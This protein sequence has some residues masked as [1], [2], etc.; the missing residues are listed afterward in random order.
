VTSPQYPALPIHAISAQIVSELSSIGALVLCAPTGSGKT[1][2]VPQI[3]LRSGLDHGGNIL[4]LQP[5]RLATRLVATRVADEM[6]TSLGDVVGFQTRLESRHSA[7]TRILF[8]TEGLFLRRLL[9]DPQLTGIGAVIIDEFHERSLA[10]DMALGLC[11]QLRAAGRKDLQLVVMSATLDANQVAQWLG[12]NALEAQGR[13]YPVHIDYVADSVEVPLWERA[14]RALQQWLASGQDG[15][16][17]VFMPGAYEIRRCVELFSA[18]WRADRQD[19]EVVPLHGSLTPKEQ[20]RAVASSARR[21]IIV[22]TNVAET[23]I[24]ID[25]I[26]CVIDAGLARVARFDPAR[27]VNSLL[28]ERISMASAQQ[29]AGRAGRTAPGTCLRL[30]PRSESHARVQQDTPEVERVDLSQAVLQLAAM[31]CAAV[32]FA[33]LDLPPTQR[34]TDAADQL[35]RLGALDELGTLTAAGRAMANIPAHPRL[36]RLLSLATDRGVGDRAA[37]W[38]ALI[39]ERDICLRPIA[40]RYRTMADDGWPSDL[41]VRETGL[42]EAARHRFDPQRCATLGLNAA[43]CREVHRVAGQFLRLANNLPG[44]SKDESQTESEPTS[45]DH[46]ADEMLARCL[47]VAYAD[48]VGLRRNTSS[49]ACEMEGRRRVRLDRD[50]SIGDCP[51]FVAVELREV[52]ASRADGGGVQ[53]IASLATAIEW[54]WLEEELPEQVSPLLE[55]EWDDNEKAVYQIDG[56]RFGALRLEPRRQ[57]ARNSEAAAQ[58]II[59]RVL[60][61]S[62]QFDR[63]D[64]TV[65]SWLAR[66]RCVAEWFPERALLSYEDDDLA[67]V[68]GE[69]VGNAS[70]WGA[71]RQVAVLDHLRHALSWEDQQFVEKMAPERIQLPTGHGMRIV[72]TPGEPPRGRAKI[73]DLY[74]V[75]ATPKVAA[76]RVGLL[77]EILAPNFRPAQITDDL[78]GFWKRTYPELK[79]ELKRRY[80]K[81]EWR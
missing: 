71:V 29:R 61:G 5:R 3:L 76:G 38:A 45:P 74:D 60:E 27:G 17:L 64:E 66:A 11:R 28:V 34:L 67:V 55:L 75:K 4:V 30:W 40:N 59:D 77:L 16:V 69:M 37:V 10:A 35:K 2:Q 15:H 8:L 63:W 49:T 41:V 12:C 78:P 54:Q 62:L 32:D 19:L 48:H 7:N 9:S 47:L 22:S 50:S 53:T 56:K 6:G 79:K 52:E 42:A 13:T 70:R 51:T 14:A 80:P 44:S 24:T 58:L 1:T 36:A 57:R 43:A 31:G 18:R 25:G 65:E 39:S 46:S 33:W 72:Y 20:D 68:I 81:H 23:S 73:Q 26:G 21:K